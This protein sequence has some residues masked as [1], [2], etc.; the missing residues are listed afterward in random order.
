MIM[1]KPS[2][3]DRE[4][5]YVYDALSNS[6]I[7]VGP[8]IEKFENAWAKYNGMKYGVSCT[9]GTT[10][11][12]LAVMALGIGPGDEVI[13]PEF[14]M[15]S[16]AW[17][18]SY[19]GASPIFVDCGD[20]LNMDYETTKARVHPGTKAILVVPIYGRPVDPRLYELG[21]PVIEDM[22][23]AHGIRPQG[24]IACYS[25]YGNKILTT[26]EGG[27]CLTDNEEW[28]DKMFQ[29]SN[30][31]MNK[32]R[33]M[34][35]EGQGYNYRMTNLQAAVGLAQVERIDEILAKRKQIETWYDTYLPEKY[36]MPTR[37]VLWMYD[38]Q[39]DHQEV[40][41]AYLSEKGVP[42]RY[43]FKPMSMQ[44]QYRMAYEHLNAY[45]WSKRIL[46]LPTHFDLTETEVKEICQILQ[47]FVPK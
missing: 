19:T 27:M 8:Y 12:H 2:I 26:G 40:L 3:T 17:A 4:K 32:E 35:H 5:E 6:D 41:K 15:I 16:T 42:T 33:T 43:G 45:K 44:P 1:S 22:A 10:A 46:Y 30:A 24:D 38:I 11:L 34:L 14:T 9:S 18:V 39:T 23:E 20:D 13:V 7:G 37:D 25:F 29:L 21:V 36:K 31:M 47:S 28:R